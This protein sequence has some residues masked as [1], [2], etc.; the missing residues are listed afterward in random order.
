MAT[1]QATF[2]DERMLQIVSFKKK[3]LFT[4]II[5]IQYSIL[6][7]NVKHYLNYFKVYLH[8]I[9]F[10]DNPEYGFPNPS[11]ESQVFNAESRAHLI[12]VEDSP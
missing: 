2:K 6:L 8:F 1:K 12:A 9:Y 3:N 4:L 7:R 11:I 5:L 10:G